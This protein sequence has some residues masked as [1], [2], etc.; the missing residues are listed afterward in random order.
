MILGSLSEGLC[1]FQGQVG[2]A[3]GVLIRADTTESGRKQRRGKKRTSIAIV[4]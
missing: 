1:W 2:N 3:H 4:V